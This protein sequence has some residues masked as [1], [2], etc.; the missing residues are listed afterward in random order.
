MSW[1]CIGTNLVS[2]VPTVEYYRK[3]EYSDAV[4]TYFTGISSFLFH[5]QRLEGWDLDFTGIRNVDLIMA[6]LLIVH[7]INYLLWYKRRFEISACILPF[8]I[9]LAEFSILVRFICTSVYGVFCVGMV[10]KDKEHYNLPYFFGGI[11]FIGVDVLCFAFG[12]EMYY[13][14]LHGTH[15]VCAFISQLLFTRSRRKGIEPLL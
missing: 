14:W 8:I 5:G 9:Y 4:I 3:K 15:H 11:G 1:Y 2:L 6:N 12:N 13:N 7:V 10:I